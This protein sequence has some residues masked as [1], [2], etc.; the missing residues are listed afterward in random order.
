MQKVRNLSRKLSQLPH[1]FVTYTSLSFSGGGVKIYCGTDHHI[2]Y[3]YLQSYE[4]SHWSINMVSG[5][6]RRARTMK[7]TFILLRKADQLRALQVAD[8]ASLKSGGRVKEIT[9]SNN[10]TSM[11]IADMLKHNFH[12]LNT[13]EKISR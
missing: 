10:L 9:F 13:D 7:R 4:T 6:A 11:H 2:I 8:F 3:S 1:P 12:Q 5:N